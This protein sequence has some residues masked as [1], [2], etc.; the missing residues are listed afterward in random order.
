MS[1]V[2]TPEWSA[3]P[4]Q[5][6]ILWSQQVASP[7]AVG[8]TVIHLGMAD[9]AGLIVRQFKVIANPGL[10]KSAT[11]YIVFKPFVVTV[12]SGVATTRY[13]DTTRGTNVHQLTTGVPYR[14]HTKEILN[15]RLPQGASIGVE[16]QAVGP[17]AEPS[18]RLSLMAG[19]IH[20]R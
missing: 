12:K 11:L 1:A 6:T 13:Y 5:S 18:V 17:P 9:E 3:F 10:P 15:D 14:L 4:Y 7:L 20:E 2:N 19:L 8:T 16:I